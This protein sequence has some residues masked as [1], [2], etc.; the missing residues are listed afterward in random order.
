MAA[1]QDSY[2]QHWIKAIEMV[3]PTRSSMVMVTYLQ[4]QQPFRHADYSSAVTAGAVRMRSFP[5]CFSVIQEGAPITTF[6][7][8]LERDTA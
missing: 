6:M 3:Y 2:E 7:D 4:S 8:Q 1:M 5:R